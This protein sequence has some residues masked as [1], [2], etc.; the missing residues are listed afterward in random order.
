MQYIVPYTCTLHITSSS[1]IDYIDTQADKE[2]YFLLKEEMKNE[3]KSVF[4]FKEYN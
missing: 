4:L 1:I 3:Q 2:V